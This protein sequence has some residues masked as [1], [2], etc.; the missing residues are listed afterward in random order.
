[1][2]VASGAVGPNPN[3]AGTLLLPASPT[4]RSRASRLS[5]SGR[6]V[7]L[8]PGIYAV[9]ASLPPE[10][11]AQHHRLEI[12]AAHWPGAILCDQTALAGGEPVDGRHRIR[13]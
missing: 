12:I 10:R 5:K 1:M 11:V 2:N 9:G 3:P 4:E 8:A 6:A 13:R 7:Q